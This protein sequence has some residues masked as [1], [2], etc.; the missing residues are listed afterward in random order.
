M[1]APPIFYTLC[2]F[3]QR[4]TCGFYARRSQK[5][6]MTLL[7]WLSFFAHSGSTFV[8]AVGRT[9]MKLSP[10]M[11]LHPSWESLPYNVHIYIENEGKQTHCF[12]T[13]VL[14][15]HG[16]IINLLNTNFSLHFTLRV[17]GWLFTWNKSICICYLI[18]SRSHDFNPHIDFELRFW[19]N[20]FNSIFSEIT[21]INFC[22]FYATLKLQ[23][24]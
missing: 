3:H 1:R 17:K 18:R 2:Q 5:R 14:F 12:L 16:I 24:V 22:T 9:L 8:K 11:P 10:G 21:K 6:Q 23:N 7:T 13:L 19:I 15:N 20:I 4:F